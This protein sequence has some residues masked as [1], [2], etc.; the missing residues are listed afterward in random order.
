MATTYS[1]YA[2]VSGGTLASLGAA[3][4]GLTWSPD[5]SWGYGAAYQWRVDST[6]E[7][8]TTTGDTWSFTTLTFDPPTASWESLP[9]KTLGPLNGGTVGV[10]FLW[11]GIN[12]M[13]TTRRLIAAARNRIWYEDL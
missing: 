7:F 10:D 12:N 2:V 11:N 3:T 6:N 9:G 1:V 8:G 5:P 4:A 13:T